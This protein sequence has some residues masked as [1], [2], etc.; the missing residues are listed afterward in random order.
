MLLWLL[1]TY[2]YDINPI[3]DTSRPETALM[4]LGS[5]TGTLQPQLAPNTLS[6][7]NSSQ[8]SAGVHSYEV[9]MCRDEAI[10]HPRSVHRGVVM[11][12]KR[13]S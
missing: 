10:E 1:Q 13:S 3:R 4:V 8:K 5:T 11:Q 2:T 12:V 6:H 7:K 9:S